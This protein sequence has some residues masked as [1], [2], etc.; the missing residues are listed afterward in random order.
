[1]SLIKRFPLRSAFYDKVLE[2]PEIMERMD[3]FL[4]P[5]FGQDPDKIYNLNKALEIQKPIR[6]RREEE[7]TELLDLDEDA[8]QEE[9]ERRLR[10]KLKRY[11][12]SLSFLL[13]LASERERSRWRKSAAGCRRMRSNRRTGSG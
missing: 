6:R 12:G 2:K 11:E 13:E 4:R 3:L 9:Q 5:L 1:M 10:E 8:W 7:E